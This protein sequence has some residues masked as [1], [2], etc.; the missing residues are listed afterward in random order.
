[1]MGSLRSQ[2]KPQPLTLKDHFWSFVAFVALVLFFLL[3][4]WLG[5]VLTFVL[6]G[7][8]LC[9]ILVAKF[10]W[11][12]QHLLRVQPEIPVYRPSKPVAGFGL[13]P[14][15]QTRTYERG[16]QPQSIA[17][18]DRQEPVSGQPKE[19]PP[20]NYEQPLAQYPEQMSPPMA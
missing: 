19:E 13:T 18:S 9:I 1:M 2:P 20:I 6:L 16:Y 7:L 10:G 11:P 4:N 14:P 12:T 8:L 5:I 15:E 3:L 17:R